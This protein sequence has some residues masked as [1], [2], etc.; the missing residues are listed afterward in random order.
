MKFK[1]ENRACICVWFCVCVFFFFDV[2]FPPLRAGTRESKLLDPELM[3][4]LRDFVGAGNGNLDTCAMA[5]L[6]FLY[7]YLSLFESR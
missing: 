6:S 7:L 2:S 3:R 4:G 1:I 5:T